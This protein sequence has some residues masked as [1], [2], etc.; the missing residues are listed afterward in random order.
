MAKSKQTKKSGFPPAAAPSKPPIIKRS[1]DKRPVRWDLVLLFLAITFGGT[2]LAIALRPSNGPPRYTYKVLKTYPHDAAAFTQGLLMDDGFLWESTGR[3]G[4][5]SIRKVNFETGEVIKNVP[6][7]DQFFGEGL[8]LHD[9]KFY[10]LTWQN[11]RA[12]VYDRELNR[13]GEVNYSGEGWGLC[14]N[15]TDLIFS[16]GTSEIRFL[17][18]ATF[19]VRRSMIVRRGGMRAGRL[20][21]LE[22]YNGKIY[23]NVYQSDD[24]YE[25]D[26]ENGEVTAW[27]DLSGL[28]P[29]AER[30]FDGVLNGIAFNPATNRLLVTGKLCP[31]IYEIELLLK[32]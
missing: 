23:A 24:I 12:F 3:L 19:E 27:I 28:W 10:Q 16:N 13:V 20:N 4:E 29:T 14:S 18:P 30:P 21:E 11:E 26:P 8:A 7:E 15:G 5:S 31:K 22:F 6:L 32:D 1:T 2:Y 25:I 17:D 9:D